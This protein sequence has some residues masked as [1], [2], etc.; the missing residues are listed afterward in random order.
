MKSLL[1][2]YKLVV[3]FILT[4]LLVYIALSVAYK[5]YLQFSDG[6]EYYPDYMTHLVAKQS[7]A[8]LNA[9]GYNTQVLPHPDEPSMKVIVNN[10]Y[11]ARV[12][13]GCNSISVIILFASFIVAFASNFKTTLFYILSGSV[14]IYVVN[15]LRIV[16]LTIAL[17]I[18]PH[19]KDVFHTVVFP[20]IIYNLVF[21]LWIFWVNRF[22]KFKKSN[23]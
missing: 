19:Q 12:I 8:L 18:Y 13:E 15:L 9:L 22:S 6:S 23:G 4:F 10:V 2:K 17:Y 3:R 1:L 21:L 14:L 20:A 7:E 11:L 5:F 16:L